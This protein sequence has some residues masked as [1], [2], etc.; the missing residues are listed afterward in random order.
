MTAYTSNPDGSV[1]VA[2]AYPIKVEGADVT[3][4]TLKRPKTLDLKVMDQA[5]GDTD[6]TAR[7]IARLANVPPSSVDQ[8]DGSDFTAL[9]EVVAGFLRPPQPTGGGSSSSSGTSE[10]LDT[11]S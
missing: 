3:T 1:T 9:S 6:K 8:L 10:V 5:K 2:L 11:P 4:L 7:L